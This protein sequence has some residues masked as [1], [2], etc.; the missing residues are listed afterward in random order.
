MCASRTNKSIK[1]STFAIGFYFINLILQ[2]YSRKIFL[3]YLGTEILGLNTT[4]MNL[5]QFLNLAELG[6][7]AG[8]S[9]MLYKPLHNCDYAAISEIISLQGKL[10][11]RIATLIIVG[12]C[13]LLFFFPIIFSKITIPIIYAYASFL[14]LLFSSLI[15]YFFNYKQIIFTA[16]Q[17]DFKVLYGYKSITL[18]KILVQMFAVYHFNNGYDWWLVLEVVF[19]II[20]SLSLHLMTIKNFPFLKNEEKST[21]RE[22]RSKY[23]EL[24]SK[25][26]QLFFHKIG[27]FAL[28]QSSPIIIYAYTNLSEVALYGNY[29]IIVTGIQA[30][31]NSLFNSINAGIGDLVTEGDKRKQLKVFFELFS[32]RFLFVVTACFM[33]YMLI[34]DF[35]KLW[36]GS[37]YLLQNSTLILI[38]IILYI[39]TFRA[40]VDSFLYAYGLFKDTWAPLVEATLN[41]SLSILL[42]Y[43]LGLNGVLLGVLVSLLIVICFWKPYFLFRMEYKGYLKEYVWVY[44]KHIISFCISAGLT[45]Y[46]YKFITFPVTN[47]TSFII[48]SLILAVIFIS[49]NIITLILFKTRLYQF[50]LRMKNTFSSPR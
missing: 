17:Q 46:F 9:Y 39:N 37:Q 4:A 14:V 41:I 32:I 11:K 34:Q 35:I 21:F 20:A 12:A 1:N 38:L 6:I 28:T 43:Y 47:W 27:G 42:G 25:I 19:A 18:L 8:I 13:I 31:L 2:F 29:L 16:S 36:I 30:L 45:I 44:F 10:Y 22:L 5:L 26:K 49:L 33:G 3:E 23:P 40:T 7:T 24:E 15:G 50:I 48:Y